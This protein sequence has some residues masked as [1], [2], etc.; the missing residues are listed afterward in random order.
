MTNPYIP[1]LA[2]ITD[3]RSETPTVNTYTVA[4][5]EPRPLDCNPGQFVELSLFGQ[6]EFPVSVSG[7]TDPEQGCFQVT[8]RRA[9]AVTGKLTDAPVGTTIGIRGPFG[10]GFPL[11][12]LI[13]RDVL[14]VAGGIGLCPLKNLVDSL[15]SRRDRYGR[16]TLLY[17]AVSPGELLFKDKLK[18]WNG[19]EGGDPALEVLVTVDRHDGGWEGKVGLVTELFDRVDLNPEATCAVVCG[20]HVMM[21]AA[22]SLLVD[23]GLAENQLYLSLERRM[24]CGMGM[25]GHCTV[26]HARVCE[27]GPVFRS[28]QLAGMTE[29]LW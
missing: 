26:G 22:A 4:L 20:P 23:R 25:C 6:G 27:E 14:L 2:R 9:G 1:D 11:E 21:K 7:V 24:Q 15:V 12:R 5:K 28:D 3:I 8:V 16:L 17:G 10:N 13:G 29:R 19:A 18:S